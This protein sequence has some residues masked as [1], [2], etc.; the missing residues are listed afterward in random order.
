MPYPGKYLFSSARLGFRNWEETDIEKMSAINNDP[1]VMRYFPGIPSEAQTRTFIANMQTL[2]NRKG[3]CYF[4]VDHLEDGTF[5][6]FIGLNEKDF[7]SDFTPCMDI[8]WRLKRAY[9]NKGLATE[10]AASCLAYGFQELGF[11]SIKAIAP[12]I[13]MPSISIMKKIGME[14]LR[15]FVHPLLKDDER[16]R[17]CVLYEI[18]NR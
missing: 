12:K 4:A 5:I 16:L 8:G 18:K 7:E 14:K 6:G 1:E 9:W 2:F 13:N 10:G 15:D 3:F 17:D 11:D